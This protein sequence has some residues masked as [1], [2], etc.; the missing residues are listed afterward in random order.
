MRLISILL[1]L[2]ISTSAN[3]TFIS[4]SILPST[5]SK[6]VMVYEDAYNYQRSEGD[7]M[8]IIFS[9]GYRSHL[10][11]DLYLESIISLRVGYAD[12]YE[13]TSYSMEFPV[14]YVFNIFDQKMS[15]G[16]G[17]KVLYNANINQPYWELYELTSPLVNYGGANNYIIEGKYLDFFITYEHLFDDVKFRGRERQE[18]KGIIKTKGDYLGY[19]VRF[20]F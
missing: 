9:L 15:I 17:P 5:T 2:S 14:V 1:F 18:V 4:M 8:S 7:L 12:I 3:N 13:H 20:K 19:G 6:Q 16:A 11:S 10:Y